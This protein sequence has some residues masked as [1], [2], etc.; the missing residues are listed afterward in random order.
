LIFLR[1]DLDVLHR[2][3]G[4]ELDADRPLSISDFMM[5]SSQSQRCMAGTFR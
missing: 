5:T 2:V 4:S 3:A 1:P